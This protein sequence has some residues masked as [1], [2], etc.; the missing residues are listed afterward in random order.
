MHGDTH[1]ITD[2][3]LNISQNSGEGSKKCCITLVRKNGGRQM[4]GEVRTWLREGRDENKSGGEGI[5][6]G[7]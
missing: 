5:K 3:R 7:N 1:I 2:N 4:R 6:E